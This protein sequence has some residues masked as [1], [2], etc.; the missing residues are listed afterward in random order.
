MEKCRPRIEIYLKL[1]LLADLL[2]TTAHN[3]FLKGRRELRMIGRRMGL[4]RSGR[5]LH[6]GHIVEKKCSRK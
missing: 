3:L 6:R 1:P 2:S 4:S 5:G